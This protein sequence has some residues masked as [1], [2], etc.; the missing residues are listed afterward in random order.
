MN[1]TAEVRLVL[2]EGPICGLGDAE[3]AASHS[4][5]DA[6]VAAERFPPGAGVSGA[7]YVVTLKKGVNHANQVRLAEDELTKAL[8]M[9]AA[10]WP[11][12]GGSYMTIE[13]REVVCSRRF[14]SNAH[15]LERDMLARSGLTTLALMSGAPVEWSA[16]Y[17]QAPLSL[18]ARIARSMHSDFATRRVLFYHQRA[19]TERSRPSESDRA[20]WF[21][22]LYKVRDF[23]AKLYEGEAKAKKKLKITS[24]KWE[25]FGKVLNNHDLRHAEINGS[26]PPIAGEEIDELYRIAHCWVASYLRIEK[27]LPAV[28]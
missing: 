22:S 18:A 3:I 21:I 6:I 17:S 24:A 12:S 5:W 13:T 26:A 10:A 16:T 20:S 14:E 4:L 1:G 2:T 9:L 15:H 27:G 28:G 11:F 19:V 7:N 23:L 25:Y 8:H